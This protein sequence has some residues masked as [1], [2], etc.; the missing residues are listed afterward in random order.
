MPLCVPLLAVEQRV[1]VRDGRDKERVCMCTSKST[2]CRHFWQALKEALLHLNFI[3]S[4]H[5]AG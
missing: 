4:S 2:L 1:P 3:L 5:S